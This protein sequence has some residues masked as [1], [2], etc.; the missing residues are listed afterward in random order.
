MAIPIKIFVEGIADVKFIED[1]VYHISGIKLDDHAIIDAGGWTN[2][3]STKEKG[4]KI[5]NQL[6]F[7]T[8]NG[9]VNLVIFDADNNFKERK[10]EII[11]WKEEKKLNFDLFLFPNDS[12][13]GALEELL[14]KIICP[15]NLPIFECWD[16]FEKCIDSKKIEGRDKPLTIPA[17]KTKIYG[18]LETLLGTSKSEK[19]KIK[20]RE[21]DY[22]ETKHWD[23]DSTSL[24][25]LKTFLLK[26]IK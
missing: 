26:Y 13:G 23:L 7:N 8:D 1:Y 10:S 20:E 24:S 14:E 15:K 6:M 5:F 22:K 16:Q 25:P 11:K 4:E 2:L 17:K 12:D 21:R 19:E 18:Y 3:K 9:G